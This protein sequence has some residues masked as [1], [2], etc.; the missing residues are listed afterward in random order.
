LQQDFVQRHSSWSGH[1]ERDHFGDV[2]VMASCA[3]SC[4]APCLAAGSVMWLVS[5]VATAPGS[6]TVTRMSG[7]SSCRRASD[8]H[9]HFVAA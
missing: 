6:M 7:C 9:S 5:S 4:S 1:P 8:V 3:W 2:G